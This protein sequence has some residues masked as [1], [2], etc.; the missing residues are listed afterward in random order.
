[1]AG[2]ERR[3]AVVVDRP[4]PAV[5]RFLRDPPTWSAWASGLGEGFERDGDGWI[6]R[7]PSGDA[8]LRFTAP[9]RE[10]VYD[11]I[12]TSPDGT[13]VNVPLRA[14]PSG[15]GT[16]IVLT[17]VRQPAA[18]DEERA[19]DAAWMRR[20]LETLKGLLEREAAKAGDVG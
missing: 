16:E 9:E 5:H 13:E 19:R 18:S 10:G 6:V 4:F 8:R 17:L 12:V 7:R 14:S 11:H 15:T 20:D 3:I 2:G 1:M